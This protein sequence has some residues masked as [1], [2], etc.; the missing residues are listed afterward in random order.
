LRIELNAVFADCLLI[1]ADDESTLTNLFST[2]VRAKQ[3]RYR[4][5]IETLEAGKSVAE[6]FAPVERF[7]ADATNRMRHTSQFGKAKAADLWTYQAAADAGRW[8]RRYADGDIPPLLKQAIRLDPLPSAEANSRVTPGPDEKGP[9]FA[10]HRFSHVVCRT[11]GDGPL[12][13]QLRRAGYGSPAIASVR[14]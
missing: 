9:P 1:G 8:R 4:G 6:S 10:T 14:R 12:S 13:E 11:R 3:D 2:Y 7:L 5:I